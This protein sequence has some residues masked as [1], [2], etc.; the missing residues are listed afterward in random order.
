MKIFNILFMAVIIILLCMILSGCTIQFKAKELEFETE[1]S[2]I[3]EL[4]GFDV[5]GVPVVSWQEPES[6]KFDS[7]LPVFYARNF[8]N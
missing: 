4:K 7:G 1:Q 5:F 8:Q 2:R 3:Y 6:F